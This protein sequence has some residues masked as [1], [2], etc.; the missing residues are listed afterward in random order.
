[1]TQIYVFVQALIKNSMLLWESSKWRDDENEKYLFNA[2][3][4]NIIYF[5]FY[6]M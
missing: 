5:L 4:S 1:M 3:T 6:E 2:N